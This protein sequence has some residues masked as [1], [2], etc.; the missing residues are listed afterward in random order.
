MMVLLSARVLLLTVPFNHND[1][2]TLRTAIH[3]IES[4]RGQ[5]LGCAVVGE[6][7]ALKR[8]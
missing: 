5:V 1:V 4:E 6:I 8:S 3:L 2:H 7:K